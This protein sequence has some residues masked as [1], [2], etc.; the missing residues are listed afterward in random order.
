MTQTNL[1]V[2]STSITDRGLNEK[3][4]QNEDS[5]IELRDSGLFAVADGV[6][7]AQAG[8]IASQMATEIL[9]EAFINLEEG[10]DAE[11]RM[12]VA[13]EQANSAIFQMS[14]DLPQ[15]NSMATTVV[16][17]HINQNVATIGHVGDSRLYRVDAEGNLYRETQD[18][19]VVEEEVRAGRLTPE[20][21]ETHPSRNVISRA[22]GAESTVEVDMKTIMFDAG[23]TFLIC[24]DGVTRHIGDDELRELLFSEEDTFAICQYI[25]KVCYERGAEDNLTAVVVKAVERDLGVSEDGFEAETG[26]TAYSPIVNSGVLTDS[27]VEQKEMVPGETARN[28]NVEESPD[29][30]R[31]PTSEKDKGLLS[32]LT[33]KSTKVP[34]FDSKGQSV[35]KTKDVGPYAVDGNN[36]PNM[37]RIA[38]LVLPWT[39]LGIAVIILIYL[40]WSQ[41]AVKTLP[42]DAAQLNTQTENL[43]LT[44]FEQNR[45]NVDK[46]PAGYVANSS[47]P[48]DAIDHYLFGRAFFLQK[49]YSQA[50]IHLQNSKKM[51]NDG[52]S[53]TNRKVLENE[54]P[55]M[56]TIIDNPGAQKGF[57][58][59]IKGDQN[60]TSNSN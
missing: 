50:K 9:G 41:R 55:M 3:R 7:G 57:E 31:Q 27:V 37:L 30:R 2:N 33:D 35:K 1:Q 32:V 6:G 23:T 18:H 44:S 53:S 25:K 51:L 40:F 11:E 46:D 48:K 12:K 26:A 54:I 22:L 17:L 47:T 38:F 45:R 8:D 21:A 16:G 52:V 39:L 29:T 36:A 60:D 4:A 20:Q 49:N 14:K 10:G 59:R 15:L 19:S 34:D 58:S 43:E 42:T 5:Y 28:E 13:I 24:S 56:M